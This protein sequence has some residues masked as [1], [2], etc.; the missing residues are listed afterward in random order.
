MLRLSTTVTN[1]KL[2]FLLFS[3]LLLATGAAS[4]NHPLS[5]RF[6]SNVIYATFEVPGEVESYGYTVEEAQ[7]IN[8]NL[9]YCRFEQYNTVSECK[10]GESASFSVERYNSFYS[11]I[12]TIIRNL[13]GGETTIPSENPDEPQVLLSGEGQGFDWRRSQVGYASSCNQESGFYVGSTSSP[14]TDSQRYYYCQEVTASVYPEEDVPDNAQFFVWEA[15]NACTGV[16]SIPS[17]TIRSS[18]DS[19]GKLA[20]PDAS[21]V[22]FSELYNGN[23]KVS[24]SPGWSFSSNSGEYTN[25][26]RHP[27]N[28]DLGSQGPIKINDPR[29]GEQIRFTV[30]SQSSRKTYSFSLPSFDLSVDN[31]VYSL[32]QQAQVNVENVRTDSSSEYQDVRSSS[33]ESSDFG[34]VTTGGQNIDGSSLAPSSATVSSVSEQGQAGVDVSLGLGTP[35]DDIEAT[36]QATIFAG[37]TA[38][39]YVDPE[40]FDDNKRPVE[41]YWTVYDS[42]NRRE[43][44]YEVPD[45]YDAKY[46]GDGVPDHDCREEDIDGV[47]EDCDIH[48]PE[49]NEDEGLTVQGEVISLQLVS[50]TRLDLAKYGGGVDRIGSL[51][52]EDAYPYPGVGQDGSGDDI[53]DRG[54]DVSSRYVLDKSSPTQVLREIPRLS[55]SGILTVFARVRPEAG[56]SHFIVRSD[57]DKK[58]SYEFDSEIGDALGPGY[59]TVKFNI[60]E[61]QSRSSDSYVVTVF[62][63]DGFKNP[64]F[65]RVKRYEVSGKPEL[66]G[67]EAAGSGSSRYSQLHID[68]FV[69]SR[70]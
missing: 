40:Y 31:R 13:D 64:D 1:N 32:G 9:I 33:F 3:A 26:D 38:K 47:R 69:E 29:P 21:P 50:D 66:Y 14:Q 45:A 28:S 16:E 34:S 70:R 54:D 30:Q 10:Q 68:W 48:T 25:V 51:S 7:L 12:R 46:E 6:T 58:T 56:N 61:S 2:A 4:S 20:C 53:I 59:R 35:G 37:Q 19:N 41:Q 23:Y 67:F 8:S 57:G 22:S 52:I 44:W 62:R 36:K 24:T 60:R 39:R 17:D 18:I 63:S 27:G 65:S 49:I 42:L 15:E 5:E 43:Y 55:S 11:N